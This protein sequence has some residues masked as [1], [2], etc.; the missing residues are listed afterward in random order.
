MRH[1]SYL[2]WYIW[3][4]GMHIMI[5]NPLGLFISTFGIFFFFK[6]RIKVEDYY[7]YLFFGREYL[8]YRI[9]TKSGIWGIP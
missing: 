3:A 6:R 7:L 8:E 5:A 4:M 9:K 2:G 1:P